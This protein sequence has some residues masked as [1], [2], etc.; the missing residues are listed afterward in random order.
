MG[1]FYRL[2]TNEP[3]LEYRQGAYRNGFDSTPSLSDIAELGLCENAHPLPE[4]DSLMSHEWRELRDQYDYKFG[5]I[6]L[7]QYKNW[8]K[9]E[10]TR[11]KLVGHGVI[12]VYEVPDKFYIKG[13]TQAVAHEEEI[14]H[15]FD[16]CPYTLKRIN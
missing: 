15:K 6:S 11:K 13:E 8:F 1:T 5:F 14:E 10:E 4:E 3:D 7:T 9:G 2:E 12:G 16:L